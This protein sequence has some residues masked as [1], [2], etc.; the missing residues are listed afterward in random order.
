M[1]NIKFTVSN[2]AW[3]KNHLN[4]IINLFKKN[5]INTLE[6]SPNILLNN[7]FSK[8]N[9]IKVKNFWN[10]KKIK[11][12]SMQSILY[13][14]DDTYLFGNT[15]QKKKFLNE[16]KKKI[17]IAKYLG[18]KVIVF[19]S[20][21]NK[22]NIF[23]KSIKELDMEAIDMFKKINTICKKKKI[24]FCLEA[25]PKIY[26]CEYLNYTNHA[27]QIAKKINSNFFKV[28]LDVGTIIQNKENPKNL[29]R[30]NLNL[31]GHCQLSMPLLKP[32]NFKNETFKTVITLLKKYKYD[33]I[34]SI[35]MLPKK[36]NFV[37]L[38]S[39]IKFLKKIIAL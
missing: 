15:N 2:I 21:K 22:K 24:I 20:P 30:N 37:R 32:I 23:N 31:I 19:G 17:I 5:H 6:F 36:I 11:L 8:K 10:K 38:Q 4:K 35:E 14:L 25:N 29:I 9:I 18:V 34:I 1:K 39:N 7:N 27:F 12:Y 33:G 26:K 13:G 3:Q 28:N 16:V